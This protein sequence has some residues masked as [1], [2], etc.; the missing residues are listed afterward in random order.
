M[1]IIR[2]DVF[3]KWLGNI[4]NYWSSRRSGGGI[5]LI[6]LWLGSSLLELVQQCV[7]HI[8][9]AGGVEK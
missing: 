9:G 1:I 3:N 4:D 2:G 6:E 8:G 7:V 5:V